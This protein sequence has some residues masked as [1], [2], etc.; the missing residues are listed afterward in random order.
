MGTGLRING[1]QIRLLALFELKHERGPRTNLGGTLWQWVLNV[2][3][4]SMGMFNQNDL[5]VNEKLSL[6][7]FKKTWFEEGEKVRPTLVN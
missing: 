1:H 7:L 2:E 4:K 5:T 3:I 6:L